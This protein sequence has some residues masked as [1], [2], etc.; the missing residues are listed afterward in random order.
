L[1]WRKLAFAR[2]S[3]F[4]AVLNPHGGP[5]SAALGLEAAAT[6]E[7]GD[8]AGCGSAA[9]MAARGISPQFLQYLQSTPE[10]VKGYFK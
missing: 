8:R 10:R 1:A 2:P 4:C 3:H 5:V 9:A 7:K 6:D